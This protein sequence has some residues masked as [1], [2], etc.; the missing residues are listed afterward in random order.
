M[1]KTK[2]ELRFYLQEDAKCNGIRKG[3]LKSFI[4]RC[5]G[6]EKA[7][8]YHWLFHFRKWEYHAN[9]IGFFH[10]FF[11]VYHR[12]RVQRI[13]LKLGIWAQINTIGY[14]LRIMHVTGGCILRAKRIGNYCSFNTGVVIGKNGGKD[15][16]PVIGN[17]VTFG[18]GAKAIGDITIEDNVIIAVNSVVVKSL[19]SN[20][21]YGGVPAK[22]IKKIE[23]KFC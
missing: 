6:S 11:S 14:G 9:N 20:S 21:I 23:K 1:I 5:C 16:H 22:F 7:W 2:E 19:E 10:R 12:I 13:G 18:P 8:I 17:Y 4:S 3:Y 15:S